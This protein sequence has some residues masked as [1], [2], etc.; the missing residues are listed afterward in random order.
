MSR[1]FDFDPAEYASRYAADGFAYVPKGLT[2]DYHA[3]LVRQ[4]ERSLEHQRLNQFALGHKQQALYEF[5]DEGGGLRELQEVIGAITGHDPSR[6]ILSERHIKA[7]E[8][9]AAP[10]PTPHKDRMASQVSVGFAVSVSPGSKLVLYPYDEVSVNPFNSWAEFEA[11]LWPHQRPEVALRHARK[12]EIAD[13]PRDVVLFRGNAIWHHR[14]NAAGTTMVYLKLNEFNSDPLAEDPRT[15][16]HHR[17]SERAVA[18]ANGS[19]AGMIPVIG[20]RVDSVQRRYTRQW[21]EVPGVV[22]VGEP[23]RAISEDEF[24]MLVAADGRRPVAE[25][26]ASVARD[27]AQR[28]DV[29]GKLVRL[30]SLSV[31]DLV[32]PSAN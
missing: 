2:A 28:D 29:L 3:A 8:A 25:V 22:M 1:L 14:L 6:L 17:Q 12:V 16:E 23:W 32:R 18:S 30:A 20:R 31:I 15:A 19:L 10:T 26:V 11:S 7:Y 4:V 9:Q 5:Q 24:Q 13:G 21:G 27:S